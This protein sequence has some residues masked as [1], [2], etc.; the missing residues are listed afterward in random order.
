MIWGGGFQK[1]ET[2]E[3]RNLSTLGSISNLETEYT[4]KEQEKEFVRFQ[5][6]TAASMKMTVFWD[7]AP[8]SLVDT[9]QQTS[10]SNIPEGSHLQQGKEFLK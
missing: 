4:K 8:R 7:V 3:L 5:V 9:D 2:H 6:L 1:I 10:Q